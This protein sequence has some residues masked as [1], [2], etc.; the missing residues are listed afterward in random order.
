[1][2]TSNCLHQLSSI[3]TSSTLPKLGLLPQMEKQLASIQE[4]HRKVKFR[5]SLKRIMKLYNKWTIDFFQN[6]TLSYKIALKIA[7]LMFLWVSSSL[8]QLP[9]PILSMQ[10]ESQVC[11]SSSQDT[12]C[13]TSP[14]Q[15]PCRIQ[16][17][18][19]WSSMLVS[20]NFLLL[21]QPHHLVLC[22]LFT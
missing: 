11:P 7:Y 22:L 13:Q 17:R 9:C 4:I 10:A 15:P 8:Q 16:N 2:Q 6:V 18:F 19:C 20:L 1:M 14:Y 12:L 21:L 5:I 3:K